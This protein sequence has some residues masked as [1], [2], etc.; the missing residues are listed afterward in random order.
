MSIYRYKCSLGTAETWHSHS[1]SSTTDSERRR[2]YIEVSTFHE[3]I[4]LTSL[5]IVLSCCCCCSSSSSM[6][7]YMKNN[8]ANFDSDPIWTDS[9][10]LSE[11]CFV[12][13]R[14]QQWLPSQGQ[15]A[16]SWKHLVAMHIILCSKFFC[17]SWDV[18]WRY[19]R[20]TASRC[21]V[22]SYS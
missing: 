15:A 2:R 19:C 21:Y 11:S 1:P 13:S 3:L 18:L 6:S 4:Y 22:H 14:K 20:N 5:L 8:A 9:L 12:A 10:Q 17:I 16:R 7:I